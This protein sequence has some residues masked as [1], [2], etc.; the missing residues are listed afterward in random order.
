MP[1]RGSD[2]SLIR[3]TAKIT[4]E[5]LGAILAGAAI[6]LAFLTWRLTQEGPIHLRFLS[7]YVEQALL[8]S[9][10]PYLIAIEDTVLTWAGWDRAL[11]VRA[12][13]LR[14]RDRDGRELA[15]LPEVSFTFSA[16]AMLRGVIAPS[17]IEIIGPKLTLVRNAD[18]SIAF[19][20][21]GIT[22]T[23]PVAVSGDGSFEALFLFANDMLGPPDYNKPTGYLT[24]AA[25][26]NGS[27]QMIDHVTGLTWQ[28]EGFGAEARRDVDGLVGDMFAALPQF[29]DPAVLSASL[30][31]NRDTRILRLESNVGALQMAS[32]GLIEPALSELSTVDLAVSAKVV[33]AIQ[34]TPEHIGDV[35]VIDFSLTSGA[36]A[37]DLPEWFK[38]PLPI[39]GLRVEGRVDR[40]NDLMTLNAVDIDLDGPHISA[41][42]QW[43]GAFS[44][45]A[46]DGGTPLLAAT[47]RVS[48]LPVEQFDPYWPEDVA[49][50]TRAWVVP[51]IPSGMVDEAGAELLL[52]LPANG[53]GITLQ[54]VDGHLETS[55][56]TVHYLR[57]MPP[58]TGV[59]RATFDAQTFRA[60][61]D[62]GEVGNIKVTAGDLEITGL[63]VEDQFIKIGGDVAAP[64]TDALLLLGHPRLGYAAKLGIDPNLA[65]GMQREHF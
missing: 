38:V 18:G 44:G 21:G 12:I 20:P 15:N 30:S 31:Y 47:I 4:F 63:D 5:V 35:G 61:I 32:L 50:D 57:P 58:I 45:K 17:K 49:A 53:D 62:S 19:G 43:Q 2:A 23:D 16:R 56:L 37:L 1:S 6:L 64:L 40:R 48:N 33:T 11:D 7:S 36:G 59:A 34:I 27:V 25:V 46:W 29:G 13:N 3:R 14:V 41:N 28:A 22:G 51:N 42:A 26:L 39:D 54:S 9:D 10:Q 52:R 60:T 65:G 24:S 55:D 8:H